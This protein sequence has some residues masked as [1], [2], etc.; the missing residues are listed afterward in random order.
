MT[1]HNMLIA[2][3]FSPERFAGWHMFNILIQKR[4]NLNMHLNMPASHAEQEALI[5]AGDMQVIYANPFDAAT[6]I[7]EQ[8]YRA[9]ARPIGKSDEMVIAAGANSD[10]NNLEDLANGAT[11]AMANNRDVKLIGLRLLEAV[12]LNE[13]D[14]NW[15][16]TETY[17]AAARQVI[18]GDAQAAFFLAEIFHSFSRLTKA[19]L[20]VLIESDLADIS[21]VLLIKDGFPDTDILMN[22]VLNLHNDDDGK[23]ALTELGM[24]QGFEAMD[25]E[26]AEF[27]IDLMETLMD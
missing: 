8:G 3:D 12:D 17:Q 21:H 20:N 24:P 7:R 27:M 11:I 10:I 25:E 4:A 16:V 9:V 19:Q 18:K 6:L 23:E 5:D 1:T 2:P 15:S 14:L 26:D 13:G 22:A